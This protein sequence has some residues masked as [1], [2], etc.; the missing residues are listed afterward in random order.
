VKH[1]EGGALTTRSTSW[2]SSSGACSRPST[3][4]SRAPE[5]WH[6]AYFND[7]QLM[8]EADA[9]L[10]GRKAYEAFASYVPQGD[11]ADEMTATMNGAPKYVVS[12]TL[13]EAP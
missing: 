8:G 2:D 6:F 3:A 12:N 4:S 10:L 5:T 11:P 1:R 7:G 13:S 9:T